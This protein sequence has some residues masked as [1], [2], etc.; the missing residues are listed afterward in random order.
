M[1]TMTQVRSILPDRLKR[2]R[3][4]T[5]AKDPSYRRYFAAEDDSASIRNILTNLYEARSNASRVKRQARSR[6]S[7]NAAAH[8]RQTQQHVAPERDLWQE[9]VTR[10]RR[11][12]RLKRFQ[13][14]RVEDLAKRQRKLEIRRNDRGERRF[15]GGEANEVNYTFRDAEHLLSTLERYLPLLQ[16]GER[17]LLKFGE[18]YI[19]LSLEKY[20]D[21]LGL[22]NAWTIRDVIPVGVSDEE[23]VEYII[24]K[25][26]ITVLRPHERMR[27]NWH[28]AQGEFFPYT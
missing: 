24:E 2:A 13:E 5:I 4:T 11:Q 22:V 8:R 3:F 7:H 18:K 23:L 6:I 10:E 14:R 19:T 16:S 9:M 25:K 17:F 26:E 28:R 21:I 12:E 15:F 20:E 1:P 27:A